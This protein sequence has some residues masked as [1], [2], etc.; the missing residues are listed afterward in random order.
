M[1]YEIISVHELYEC[2]YDSVK[3]EKLALRLLNDIKETIQKS[4]F[5]YIADIEE[6]TREKANYLHICRK[7]QGDL[8]T[9]YDGFEEH[10]FQGM[11]VTEKQ[12]SVICKDCGHVVSND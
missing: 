9:V 8:E 12:Y 4:P 3:D 11:P 7:C 2:L 6:F 10:E 1:S 5:K